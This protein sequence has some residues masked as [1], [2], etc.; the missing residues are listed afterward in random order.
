MDEY[1]VVLEV[2]EPS[3]FY[4]D[5]NSEEEAETKAKE[6]AES[7]GDVVIS[8]IEVK[9]WTDEPDEEDEDGLQD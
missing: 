5:A 1:R 4:V 6:D 8:V 7:F 3:I 9:K 2:A